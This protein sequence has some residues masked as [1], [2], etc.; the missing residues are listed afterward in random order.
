MVAGTGER[1]TARTVAL[2]A[3][4]L[5]AAGPL[6]FAAAEIFIGDP[7]TR[8]RYRGLWDV[9]EQVAPVVWPTQILMAL[10]H[11]REHTAFGYSIYGISLVANVVLFAILGAVCWVLV[12]GL[13]RATPG[14]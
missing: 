13:V 8:H 6:A 2:I 10:T 7:I 14:R 9:M 1:L 3:G 12:R 5:G 11:R 4:S